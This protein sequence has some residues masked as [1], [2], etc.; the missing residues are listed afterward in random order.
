MLVSLQK[1]AWSESNYVPAPLA[2]LT[3]PTRASEHSKTSKVQNYLS[4]LNIEVVALNNTPEKLMYTCSSIA[5][6]NMNLRPLMKK[7]LAIVMK[8]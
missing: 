1:E 3:V 2:L 5:R 4:C 8:L 7:K 6:N